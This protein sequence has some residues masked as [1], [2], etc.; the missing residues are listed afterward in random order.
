MDDESTIRK[1]FDEHNA[2]AAT[3]EHNTEARCVKCGHSGLLYDGAICIKSTG[4]MKNCGCHCVFPNAQSPEAQPADLRKAAEYALDCLEPI[5]KLGHLPQ[6]GES[7]GNWL[8]VEDSVKRLRAAL[9]A[10]TQPAEEELQG[11]KEEGDSSVNEVQPTA[12]PST[13]TRNVMVSAALCSYCEAA[14]I[15]SLEAQGELDRLRAELRTSWEHGR[16]LLEEVDRLRA[17][18]KEANRM[19]FAI[20]GQI[21]TG[22]GTREH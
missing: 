19:G 21:N 6:G 9:A 18:I 12:I 10:D 7:S 3:T 15:D 1:I 5:A 14:F 17:M 20:L 16:A 4:H 13:E 8:H 11:D 22:S 2:R